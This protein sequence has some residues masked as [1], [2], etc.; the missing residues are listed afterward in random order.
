MD[1]RSL[2]RREVNARF[3]EPAQFKRLVANV[4]VDGKLTGT[5]TVCLEPDGSLEIL[6]GH[7]RTEAAIEADLPLIEVL[8]ITTPLDEERKVAIQLSHNAISGN[9]NPT[10]LAELYASLDLSAKKFSGLTDSVIAAMAKI[11]VGA[12]GAAALRYETLTIQ[13][14]PEDVAAFEQMCVKL[15]KSAET[16]PL[17]PTHFAHIQSF[18]GIFDAIVRVK[19]QL[20]VMNSALAILVMAELATERLDQ[21]EKERA[22]AQPVAA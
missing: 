17:P 20:A 15:A 1:P 9:D 18:E 14:L 10:V 4:R 5:V 16:K 7:H 8:C 11:D 19:H 21:L 6:S 12:F 22:D 2:K 3:M 13:F